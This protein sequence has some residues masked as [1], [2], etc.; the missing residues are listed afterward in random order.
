MSEGTNED[1]VGRRWLSLVGGGYASGLLAALALVGP[2]YLVLPGRLVDGWGAAPSFVEPLGYVVAALLVVAG[3]VVAGRPAERPIGAGAM[4]GAAAGSVVYGIIAAPALA[5]AVLAPA[6]HG[7][8]LPHDEVAG[9]LLLAQMV[10][11]LMLAAWVGCAF[12]IA[13]FAGLGALGGS[14]ATTLQS[15]PPAPADRAPLAALSS[16]G[17]VG[18]ITLALTGFVVVAAIVPLEATIAS[19]VAGTSLLW[20]DHFALTTAPAA[21]YVAAFAGSAVV[22]AVGASQSV[23]FQGKGGTFQAWMI[24]VSSVGSALA[25]TLG[26]VTAAPGSG[27]P[28][29][30]I[31][32]VAIACVAFWQALRTPN[33]L[34]GSPRP[35][36]VRESAAAG[37]TD[38]LFMWNP[39]IV[40]ALTV[41]IAAAL[42]AVP[43]VD[44]VSNKGPVPD[45]AT[46]A[47]AIFAFSF[48]SMVP[49]FVV[50][51]V[52]MMGLHMGSS[53]LAKRRQAAAPA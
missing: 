24:A 5:V 46:M 45:M 53:Q 51:P 23:R 41:G 33:P 3:G 13:A 28:T 6:W 39:F 7:L 30:G 19:K 49:L 14:I 31:V 4:A 1:L 48:K 16:A 29:A 27:W 22:G 44:A 10:I 9:V 18:P 26:A 21:M 17:T 15:E 32:V 34:P 25:F 42:G 12:L 35:E 38:A 40:V 2:L 47:G 50:M 36:T 52:L 37:I 11:A 43:L 20:L 8:T